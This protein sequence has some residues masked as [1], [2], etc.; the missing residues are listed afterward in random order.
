VKSVGFLKVLVVA[1]VITLFG[2]GCGS[3]L[4]EYETPTSYPVRMGVAETN[5]CVLTA[6]LEAAQ[7]VNKAVNVTPSSS[8]IDV[9]MG[10]LV[11][12]STGAAG[13]YARHKGI[14]SGGLDIRCPTC[15]TKKI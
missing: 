5:Q 14:G 9:V 7:Q 4:G 15:K 1:A 3:L 2:A 6:W 12:L 11:A 13:W 8:A 10:A